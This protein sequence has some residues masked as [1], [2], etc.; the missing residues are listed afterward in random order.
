M[1]LEWSLPYSQKLPI[2]RYRMSHESA[3][4]TIF[5]FNFLRPEA[6]LNTIKN[7]NLYLEDY[8]V[9]HCYKNQ[10]VNAV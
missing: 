8:T 1:K 9:Y 5:C 3:I 2:D 7:F 10:L 6:R 4:A